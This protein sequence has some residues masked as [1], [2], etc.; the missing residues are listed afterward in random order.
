MPEISVSE[1][2]FINDTSHD[3]SK[4]FEYMERVTTCKP[5]Y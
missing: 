4:I 3:T 1:I 5:I 2:I